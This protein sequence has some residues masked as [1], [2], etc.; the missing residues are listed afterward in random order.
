M[1]VTKVTAV[2]RYSAEAKGAWRS[3]EVGAEGSLTSSNEDWETA[4]ADLYHQLG[5]QLNRL[6][7][8]GTAKVDPPA[9]APPERSH[10]CTEHQEEFKA[11]TGPHGEFYSHRIQGGGWCNEKANTS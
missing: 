5:Q 8:N 10:W 4:Q 3:I 2:L 9:E 7:A 11:K 6:W 1:R